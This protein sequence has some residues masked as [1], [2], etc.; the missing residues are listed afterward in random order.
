MKRIMAAAAAVL[1]IVGA[2]WANDIFFPAKAGMVLTTANLNDKGKVQSYSRMTVK[3]VEGSGANMSITYTVE[4]LDSKKKP[5]DSQ[6]VEITVN[7]V[8]GY[9]ELPVNNLVAAADGGVTVTGNRVRLP[10]KMAAG[11]KFE[12]VKM[13][14]NMDMGAIQSTTDI[15]ITDHRCLAVES[16][17]TPVGTFE[18]Y[19]TTQKVSTVTKM[20]MTIRANSTVETWHVKGI[21]AV[22]TIVYNDK[23]KVH[24]Q[25]ELR[26]LVR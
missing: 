5:S 18:A 19:K 20:M 8:D 3:S 25:T 7:V 24:T 12:D 26:E 13:I 14:I 10:S 11:D 16:V 15:S 6:P 9:L 22:K 4:S 1:M 17:T 21:G 23:G 2:A